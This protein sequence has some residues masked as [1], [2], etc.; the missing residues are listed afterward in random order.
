MA[1][2]GTSSAEDIVTDC[3]C[4]PYDVR[5]L[6]PSGLLERD[7][8]ADDDPQ[9]GG[10]GA[11]GGG[12]G[13]A[14]DVPVLVHGGIWAG[15]SAE[16]PGCLVALVPSCSHTPGASCHGGVMPGLRGTPMQPLRAT[17]HVLHVTYTVPHT[18]SPIPVKPQL[19]R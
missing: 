12:G 7:N 19:P 11:G 1:I 14:P 5:H 13:S 17:T 15:E 16:V 3:L 10:G 4:S 9:E 2:R 6:L 8:E 18:R